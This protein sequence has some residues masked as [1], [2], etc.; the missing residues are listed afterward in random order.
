MNFR[1]LSFLS[2]IAAATVTTPFAG[3]AT[4]N[5]D[6]LPASTVVSGVPDIPGSVLTN[7]LN[8]QG[9]IFGLSGVSAGVAVVDLTPFNEISAPNSIVGLDN[10]GEIPEFASADIYFQFVVPG[11]LNPGVTGSVSFYVGDDCCD[12]DSMNVYAYGFDG[13]LLDTQSLSGTTWQFYSFTAP[14]IHRIVVENTSPHTAGYALDDLTF[15]DPTSAVP[16][17]AAQYTTGAG[18]VAVL[19]ALAMRRR[20]H[21]R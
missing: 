4:I 19:V 7:Q 9:V 10:A 21:L 20:R 12:T 13:T 15:N 1:T 16:E 14:G 6:L 2:L 8:G 17:P 11:T 5:F 3:A 18:M